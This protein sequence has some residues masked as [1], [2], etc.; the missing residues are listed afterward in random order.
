M[1]LVKEQFFRVILLPTTL[2]LSP[3]LVA[4]ENV[5]QDSWIM[6]PYGYAVDN[7]TAY[8]GCG[9]SYNAA[10]LNAMANRIQYR[11]SATK[12]T[13]VSGTESISGDEYKLHVKSTTEDFSAP[14]QVIDSTSH[15]KNNL[16]QHCA[17]II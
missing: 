1:S 17:L 2:F 7:S 8:S 9:N 3:F 14:V 11:E 5:A 15:I 6:Y 10:M 4:D 13:S 12:Q 16:T